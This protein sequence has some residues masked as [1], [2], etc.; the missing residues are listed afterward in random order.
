[1]NIQIINGPNLNLLGTREPHIYGSE[2]LED[3]KKWFEFETIIKAKRS[4][5]I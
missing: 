4:S 5:V 3:I 2:N 1:M